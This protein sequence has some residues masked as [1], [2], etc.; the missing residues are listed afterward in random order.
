MTPA[1][2]STAYPG[3][4]LSLRAGFS[5]AAIQG[6]S[7]KSRVKSGAAGIVRGRTD[8]QARCDAQNRKLFTMTLKNTFRTGAMAL[9]IG[10]LVVTAPAMGQYRQ[11]I[12]NDL[13][14]CSASSKSA[15]KVTVRGIESS[16][17]KMR[18]QS[19]KGISSD[20]LEKG[21]WLNRIETPASAGTMVFCVPMPGPG[22]YG[23]AVRHDKNG[24]GS[25]DIT[26]DGGGM[27][28]NPSIS[29]FNLGKPSY[30]KTRFTVGDGVT[31]ITID[32]KYM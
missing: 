28:N 16:S 22:T 32:M 30:K 14:K 31:S 29:I 25:T 9:A 20:W 4:K 3:R 7:R 24:N 21:K 8:I 17:G 11:K 27:S 26:K 23:I 15:V 5:S 2:G 12:G 10:G 19:Y 6:C 18:V 13:S 1:P